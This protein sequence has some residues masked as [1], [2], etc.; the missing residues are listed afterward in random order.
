MK[1]KI[2]I[3]TVIIAVFF[4]ISNQLK[5]QD[6]NIVDPVLKF[7]SFEETGISLN[8]SAVNYESRFFN[9]SDSRYVFKKAQMPSVDINFTYGY[10]FKRDSVFFDEF[11]TGIFKTGFNLINRIADVRDSLDNTFRFSANYI[12]IPI[13]YGFRSPLK[14]NTVKNNLY[15][16]FEYSAGL[17]ISVPYLHIMHKLDDDPYSENS[18]IKTNFMFANYLKFGF[19]GEIVFTALNDKGHGHKFGIRFSIDFTSLIKIKETKNE[20]YPCFNTIGIFYNISN[21]YE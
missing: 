15:R 7:K 1:R 21:R 3:L 2:K 18:D 8:T 4:L 19:I 11:E 17:Y 9:T 13:Q 6:S 5:A 14:Y 20:L 12:Q 10:F 16:A